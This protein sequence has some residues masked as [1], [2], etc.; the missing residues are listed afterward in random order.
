SCNNQPE[1]DGRKST[2]NGPA[3]EI[4]DKVV[5]T[6]TVNRSTI[7]RDLPAHSVYNSKVSSIHS[8]TVIESDD[9]Y[10]Y[11]EKTTEVFLLKT[12]MDTTIICAEGTSLMISAGSFI[13]EETGQEIEGIIQVSVK[14]YY[15]ISDILLAKLSTTSN[16]ELLETGGMIHIS[17]SANNERC[18]LKPGKSV[19]IGFP[20]VEKKEGMQLYSGQWKNDHQI[21]WEVVPWP[22]DSETICF[23]VSQMPVY[24]GGQK[25]MRAFIIKTIRYPE[26]AKADGIRGTVFIS[27]VVQKDSFID[28]V[29]VERGIDPEC[30]QVVLAAV[31][32]LSRFIPG[33]EN[34]VPVDVKLVLPVRFSADGDPSYDTGFRTGFDQ[35]Y[36]DTTIN[37]APSYQINRYLFSKTQLGW[38]NCDR[39]WK[40]D[41]APK[42]NFVVQI[43]GETNCNSTIIFHRFKAIMSGTTSGNFSAF[44]AIPSGEAI[45]LIAVKYMNNQPYLALKETVTSSI[46]EHELVFQPVNFQL[47]KSA[48]KKL[49]ALN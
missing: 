43:N 48:M 11:F 20:A 32:K 41:G 37:E 31:K 34:G 49:D 2:A 33:T 12:G 5:I 16:G 28:E 3:P 21:N 17:V 23:P 15:K 1:H 10:K 39:F 25:N 26:K 30:D 40:Y 38:I 13:S 44:N 35:T 9:I 27:M 47:L 46:T 7:V 42:V 8:A 18:V 29:K 45:T 24:P 22:Y 36:N 4:N 19:G 14:E 6:D